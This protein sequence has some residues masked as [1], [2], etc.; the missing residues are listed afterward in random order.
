MPMGLSNLTSLGAGCLGCCGVQ[1]LVMPSS[2]SRGPELFNQVMA[3]MLMQDRQ[4][5]GDGRRSG[6]PHAGAPGGAGVRLHQRPEDARPA[7]K[8]RRH[9]EDGACSLL[10]D[11]HLRSHC[12]ICAGVT[13]HIAGRW[14]TLCVGRCFR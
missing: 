1:Q 3:A 9:R 14:E 2:A 5:E 6:H 10:A 4:G 7:Q 11:L 12:F 13:L 8:S